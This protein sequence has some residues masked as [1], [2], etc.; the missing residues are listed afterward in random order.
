MSDVTQP[1]Q[2][3][4]PEPTSKYP[5][6]VTIKGHVSVDLNQHIDTLRS[7]IVEIEGTLFVDTHKVALGWINGGPVTMR[8]ANTK[9]AEPIERRVYYQKVVAWT[10]DI[11]DGELVDA[12]G[13]IEGNHIF[14]FELQVSSKYPSTV[15]TEYYSVKYTVS[16]RLMSTVPPPQPILKPTHL[17]PQNRL[18]IFST[19]SQPLIHI[20]STTSQPL[21]VQRVRGFDNTPTNTITVS[22]PNPLTTT[23]DFQNPH[24]DPTILRHH[25][26]YEY[27]HQRSLQ[28]RSIVIGTSMDKSISYKADMAAELV[29]GVTRLGWVDLYLKLDEN[30]ECLETVEFCF[31]QVTSFRVTALKEDPVLHVVKPVKAEIDHRVKIG[32]Y[33]TLPIARPR[34]LHPVNNNTAVTK[35]SS[36]AAPSTTR[37]RR[38]G[39]VFQTA[40][41]QRQQQSA[42][43]PQQS[44]SDLMAT[45]CGLSSCRRSPVPP[46]P[47]PVPNTSTYSH[48]VSNA[49]TNTPPLRNAAEPNSREDQPTRGRSQHRNHLRDDSDTPSLSPSSSGSNTSSTRSRSVPSPVNRSR[50]TTLPSDFDRNTPVVDGF[51]EVHSISDSD[52]NESEATLSEHSKQQRG[53]RGKST[54]RGDSD[55]TL[56]T[57]TAVT[58]EEV[59]PVPQSSP[60]P[61]NN[62]T[63]D[64]ELLQIVPLQIPS[65]TDSN[66]STYH[67]SLPIPLLPTKKSTCDIFHP[68][69][70]MKEVKRSHHVFVKVAYRVRPC[71]GYLRGSEGKRETQEVW[72][73]F[74]SQRFLEVQVPVRIVGG[75]L[76][77][78]PI[79]DSEF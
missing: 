68:S 34:Q 30:V 54:A 79:V 52:T 9:A 33:M 71:D 55:A 15:S 10:S 53:K 77:R 38:N 67:L 78:P 73:G 20:F 40:A 56:F 18:H 5:E 2:Q 27:S 24:L 46:K 75:R 65:A 6:T 43:Q 63:T 70:S 39:Q 49:G 61:K 44:N 21:T 42:S 48:K 17:D 58:S 26:D 51:D 66:T 37:D 12:D 50:S 19:T 45:S 60:R 14:P 8:T 25:S 3:Q 35:A 69:S 7:L 36:P 72:G 41:E 4:T 22:N 59:K 76:Q 64:N 28:S 23:P 16:A 11:Q 32:K 31:K 29:A 1:T 74:R 47:A 13:L 62:I 57:N